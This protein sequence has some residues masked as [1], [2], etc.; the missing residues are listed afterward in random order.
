VLVAAA[1][2]MAGTFLVSVV[3]ARVMGIGLQVVRAFGAV[4][5]LL[6]GV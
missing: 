6:N 4:F 1:V 2:F 3:F 5:R